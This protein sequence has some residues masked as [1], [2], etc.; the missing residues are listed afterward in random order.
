MGEIVWC[1]AAVG[2]Q[3]NVSPLATDD[4][5]LN[6]EALS[7]GK[8][9]KGAKAINLRVSVRNT[10]VYPSDGVEYGPS[11]TYSGW[12]AVLPSVDGFTTNAVGWVDC[13]S[14]GDIYQKVT[15]PDATLAGL[16]NTVKAVQL[17]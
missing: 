10:P 17:R 5:V 9:P 12:L 14:N 4:K 11:S 13:D 3:Q 16:Y 8:I 15:E 6:L 1:E 7:S 2:V